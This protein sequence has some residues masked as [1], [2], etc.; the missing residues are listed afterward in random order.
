MQVKTVSVAAVSS[1]VGLNIHKKKSVILK[2][3]TTGTNQI[4]LDKETLEKVETFA[5]LGSTI[6]KLGQS[7]ADVKARINEANTTFSCLKKI[8][9]S[10]Q[11]SA[12]IKESSIQTSRQFYCTQMQLGELLQPSL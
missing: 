3:N 2:Y 11:L 9:D 4:T 12:R 5:Y 10:K 8:R 7:D 1:A 6:D